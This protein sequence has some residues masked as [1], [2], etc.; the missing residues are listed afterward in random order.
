[1]NRKLVTGNVYDK[2]HSRNPIAQKLMNG[3]MQCLSGYVSSLTS[4]QS[5]LEVGCGE[6]YLAGAI[7]ELRPDI[8]LCAIDIDGR[9]VAEARDMFPT[10]T[11]LVA[12]I[13]TLPWENNSF[14]LVIAAE[15]L[16]HLA[17][18]A[19]A[20]RE[21]SRVTRQYLLA[22][23]PNEPLWR[24]LN[25]LGCRYVRSLGNTPGHVQHWNTTSFKEF[26]QTQFA[27]LDVSTPIPWSMVLAEKHV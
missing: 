21:I 22:S 24:I 1:M 2:Y 14:D 6:G 16:E 27:V 12:D 25:C 18:P 3:F 8:D 13:C 10:V 5:I 26:V 11:F 17:Q 20:L 9:L 4:V 15:V 23:V 7:R 19:A